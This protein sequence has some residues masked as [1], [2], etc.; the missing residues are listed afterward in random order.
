MD[1]AQEMD[2]ACDALA[3]EKIDLT[4]IRRDHIQDERNEE[5]VMA[6]AKK[7]SMAGGLRYAF[8]D[9][10]KIREDLAARGFSCKGQASK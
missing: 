7:A 4:W 2:A 6:W 8:I 10:N 1:N 3:K 5:R 9:R